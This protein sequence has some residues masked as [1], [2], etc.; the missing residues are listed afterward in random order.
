MPIGGF[1]AWV[2]FFFAGTGL[3]LPICIALV[4]GG[5]AM[6]A[7]KDQITNF[8]IKQGYKCPKCGCE[9]WKPLDE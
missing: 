7:F 4:V 2:T 1:W 8:I 9:E 5:S 3:A 6:L